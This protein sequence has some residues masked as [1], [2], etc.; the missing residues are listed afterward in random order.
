MKVEV[1]AVAAVVAAVSSRR[2]HVG[3]NANTSDA[4]KYD[5]NNR[6]VNRLCSGSG[7]YGLG[8]NCS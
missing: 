5:T 1:P 2:V 6:R 8:Y 3:N 7:N 4:A